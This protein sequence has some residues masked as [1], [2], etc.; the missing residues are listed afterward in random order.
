MIWKQ[1][2]DQV[3]KE[4]KALEAR[5][6]EHT[7]EII[8][9]RQELNDLESDSTTSSGHARKTNSHQVDHLGGL[10]PRRYETDHEDSVQ[11]LDSTYVPATKA[12]E[13]ERTVPPRLWW[14]Q[15]GHWG[16]QNQFKGFSYANKVEDNAQMEVYLRRAVVEVLALQQTGLYDQLASKKWCMGGRKHLDKALSVGV[17]VVD[18]KA[19]LK[20]DVKGVVK[21]LQLAVEEGEAPERIAINEARQVRK[22]WDSTWKSLVLDDS[23][24]FL[25]RKRLYQLTGNFI[26]DAKAGAARTVKHLMTLVAR[27]PPPAKLADELTRRGELK[28]L[29]N[30]AVHGTKISIIAKE[31]AIG[32]WK[33]IRQ[34]L[35][36]RNLPVLGAGIVPQ[37]KERK[38]MRGE[39]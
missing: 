34:E 12:T 25:L 33:L 15:K 17:H 24:K 19:R 7:E 8:K 35:Q 2:P 26:P 32:R 38:W 16:P 1:K 3:L 18:G 9:K 14:N 36:K 20:G 6:A 10:L 13:L 28:P 29:L 4:Q 30:V 22:A 27:K 11:A 21:N 39:D 31:V 5:Q 23:M 37:N